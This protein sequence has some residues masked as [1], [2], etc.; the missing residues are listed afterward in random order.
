ME[1]VNKVLKL[2]CILG[3]LSVCCCVLAGIKHIKT[4]DSYISVNGLA[5][6]IIKSDEATLSVMFDVEGN[7]FSDIK[8]TLSSTSAE[9]IAF[10]HKYG[11]TDEEL[12]STRDEITDRIADRYYRYNNSS[13]EKPENRYSIRRT[14]VV[15]T[16]QVDV[17][18]QLSSHLSDLYDKDICVSISEKYSSSDPS[19]IRL[20]LLSEAINDA[21]ARAS[22]IANASGV[23]TTGIK[24]IATGRF[25]ILDADSIAREWS[26]GEDTYLKRYRVVVTVS[27]NKE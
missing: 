19:K 18:R 8:T 12:V 5:D 1:I 27:F 22:K 24:S 6:R 21:K 2:S 11:F 7:K 4:K 25:S 14:I 10:L 3:I 13:V 9:V 20:E 16:K 15:K 23:K 17:A 26:D